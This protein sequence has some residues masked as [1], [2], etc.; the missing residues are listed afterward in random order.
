M[1]I[2][3][4]GAVGEVTGSAYLVTSER[5]RVLVDFGMFQGSAD[6]EARNV[7]PPGL[8]PRTLD[9]VVL[10]HAHIDHTGRLPLLPDA[11]YRGRVYGTPATLEMTELLLRDS[12]SL[13]ASDARRENRRR[14]RAGLAPV[15]PLY[16]ENDVAAIVARFTP[17][18]YDTPVLVAPDVQ[19]TLVES[20]HILGSASIKL[21]VAEDGREKRV[22]F[23]GDIGPIGMPFLRD[24]APISGA[25]LL[26]MEATYGDRD[27]RPL[28]DTEAEFAAVVRA[29]VAERGKI[30]IPAFAV[31][32]TQQLLCYFAELFRTHAVAPFPLFLDSPLAIKALKLYAQHPELAD[33]EATELQRSGQLRRD[34]ATLEP[35][36]TAEE[37]RSLNERRGPCAIIAGSGMCTG[38]RILHHLRHNLGRRD[39]AVL[40]VGYQAQGTLGRALVDGARSVTIFGEPI[41]VRAAI[42]TINGFSAHAGQSELLAWLAPLAASRPRVVLTHGEERGRAGLAGCIQQRFGLTA[43]LPAFGARLQL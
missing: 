36:E 6:N 2:T 12:A 34:L 5:A 19:A 4:L 40:I 30:L 7:V 23:S 35:V 39:T 13:Q 17:L 21:T 28:A 22:V 24:P 20:G 41:A 15:K 3:L 42:H 14:E 43:E 25:D 27:H 8:D 16:D 38:G 29:A 32:R 9:A 1:Q 33:A 26:I 37:S 10:S 18:P 11:G 31:G